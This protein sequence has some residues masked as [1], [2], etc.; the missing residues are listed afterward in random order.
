MSLFPYF[1][2]VEQTFLNFSFVV[3]EEL[4]RTIE[5]AEVTGRV[6]DAKRASVYFEVIRCY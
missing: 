3:L 5:E 6:R 4:C 2:N 1:C